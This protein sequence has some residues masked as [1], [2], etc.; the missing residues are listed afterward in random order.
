MQN[1]MTLL[2][3]MVKIIKRNIFYYFLIISTTRCH[4]LSS[5]IFKLL[6]IAHKYPQIFSP[7][8]RYK[9]EVTSY[10]VSKPV[11]NVSCCGRNKHV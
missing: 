3:D 11:R 2:S 10:K 8:Q 4:F 7:Y 5:K 9:T 1:G 6:S